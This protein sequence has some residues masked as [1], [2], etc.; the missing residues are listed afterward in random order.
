MNILKKLSFRYRVYNSIM[1]TSHLQ[2]TAITLASEIPCHYNFITTEIDY[3]TGKYAKI[4]LIQHAKHNITKKDIRM[5]MDKL[6]KPYFSDI[7]IKKATNK[8]IIIYLNFK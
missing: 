4:K 7:S 3:Y 5:I 8:E 1:Y 2:N 6:N